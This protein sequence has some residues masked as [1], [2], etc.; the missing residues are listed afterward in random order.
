[1]LDFFCGIKDFLNKV[2]RI[3]FSDLLSCGVTSA[4]YA[5][6]DIMAD[7]MESGDRDFVW[8]SEITDEVPVTAQAVSKSLKALEQKGYIERFANEKDRRRTGVRFLEKGQSIYTTAQNEIRDFVSR[9]ELEFDEKERLEYI[10]LT[11]KFEKAFMEN[12][13]LILKQKQMNGGQ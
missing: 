8:V 6:L 4:E 13:E 1:M 12:V 3:D 5:F 11:K 9:L 2:K 10:R 7:K